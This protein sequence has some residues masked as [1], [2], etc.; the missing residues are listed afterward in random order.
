MH[1]S[2]HSS[3]QLFSYAGEILGCFYNEQI[4][5]QKFEQFAQL[6]MVLVHTEL[7]VSSL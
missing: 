3:W 5:S 4:E 1:I 6:Y 7:E 2:V